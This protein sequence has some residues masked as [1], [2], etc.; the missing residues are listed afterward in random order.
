[1]RFVRASPPKSANWG[2][3]WKTALER[4]SVT[5]HTAGC[6]RVVL[7]A[8][9]LHPPH[10]TSLSCNP[11]LSRDAKLTKQRVCSLELHPC[12]T[13]PLPQHTICPFRVVCLLYRCVCQKSRQERRLHTCL[14]AD[15]CCVVRR[16]ALTTPHL[17]TSTFAHP[18]SAVN[19]N[20]REH[21]VRF[22]RIQ[23]RRIWSA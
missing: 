16:N 17:S 22:R 7:G 4:F 6:A 2:D 14:F 3:H 1:V 15:K 12:H 9:L 19:P 23:A 8:L 18:L 13:S 11:N 21:H 20:N 10:A 5:S